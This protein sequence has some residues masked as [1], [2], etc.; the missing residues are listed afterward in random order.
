MSEGRWWRRRAEPSEPSEPSEP[1]VPV[2]AAPLQDRGA[3]DG[4][5]AF[6]Q[7]GAEAA[8]AVRF[9]TA[10]AA[11]RFV[12]RLGAWYGPREPDCLRAAGGGAWWVSDRMGLDAARE[13]A[14]AC[15]GDLFLVHG[16]ELLADHGWG[17]PADLAARAR[18][19]L[20][21]SALEPVRLIDLLRRAGLH[22]ALRRPLA[23]VSVLARAAEA[24]RI[25]RRALDLGL[26]AEH[27]LVVLSPLFEAGADAEAGAGEQRR[28]TVWE[29]T[30]TA[31]RGEVPVSFLDALDRDPTVLPCRRVG[32]RG[33]ALVQYGQAVPLPDPALLALARDQ[34]WLLAGAEF[35][36]ARLERVGEP[37]DC[38][39]LVA[40]AADRPLRDAGP[41]P[42][43]A[44][45]DTDAAVITAPRLTLAAAR[46]P[47]APVDAM[48]LREDERDLVR[49]M[50][51]GHHLADRVHLV[52]GRDL[53]LLI[54]AGGLLERLP[55]GEALHCVGPGPLYL[56]LGRRIEP[57]LPPT[58]RRALLPA[59]E[60]RAIVLTDT[61]TVAFDLSRRRPVWTL[62]AGE[63]PEIDW[64]VPEEV[65][66]VLRLTGRRAA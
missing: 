35:G 27:Q 26:R 17:E 24:A 50:L 28:T 13:L 2:P 38:S 40:L 64:Q 31:A 20:P 41:A 65:A 58:A 44:D 49:L 37:L 59:D 7:D 55:V 18:E 16:N 22:P 6:L 4:A 8:V 39:T 12:G 56:P 32:D 14:R 47:G 34:V 11:L 46:T 48:L 51:E 60:T 62:W 33:R 43:W 36:S 66:T 42:D 61:A 15:A 23:E 57:A 29:L 53:V 54:A 9:G 5:G 25:V 21:R 45:G 30:L 1:V 52:P 63:P 3:T 10:T 19:R